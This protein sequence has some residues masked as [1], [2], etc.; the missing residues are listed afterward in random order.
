MALKIS[1]L[2]GREVEEGGWR[3][4]LFLAAVSGFAGAAV[5]AIINLAASSMHDSDMMAKTLLLLVASVLIYVYSQK[6]LLAMAATT[7]E[8]T[9]HDLRLHLLQTLNRAELK[10]IEELNRNEIF[11]CI[12]TEI[13]IISDG[14]TEV[15]VLAQS[16][17]LAA[18]TLCYLALL[19]LSAFLIAAFFIAFAIFRHVSRNREIASRLQRVFQLRTELLNGFSDLIDGFKEVKLHMPRGA[20]LSDAIR[21]QSRFLS[22]RQLEIQDLF[23]KVIVTTQVDFFLLSGLM[24]FIVPMFANIEASALPKIATTTLYLTGPI[25]AIVGGLPTL[26]RVNAA[27]EAIIA[28]EGKLREI[29]RSPDPGE[30]APTE[31][32]RIRL[33]GAVFRYPATEDESGFGVGPVDLEVKRGN[34]VFITGGNGSGKSTVLK[35]VTG[36]YWPSQGRVTLD[37][38]TVESHDLVSYRNLFSTIFSDNH[39]FRKLYGV[40]EANLSRAGEYLRLV[41]LERKV[42]I[43][44]RTF[45]TL[46]LS[47]GQRKRLALFVAF[48]E[49]RPVYVFDEWA[50]DQDPQFRRKFYREILPYLKS[51]GKTVIAVT[52]D[53]R[54]FDVADILYQMEEGALALV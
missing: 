1:R 3:R 27:A 12:S 32:E 5:L 30:G 16:L 44:D 51:A 43:E 49:D 37:G 13:R 40:P 48:L 29:A 20:E 14:A 23:A 25:T 35:M 52:H 21:N 45:S 8:R 15:M 28:L 17:V 18:V 36:L 7:A 39:L 2:L 42:T 46:A 50:A 34:I 26:Q 41:E 22:A 54:Y 9:V 38:R 6:S 31:F 47:S 24:V 53:E 10:E 33:F 11:S 4:L 19:S